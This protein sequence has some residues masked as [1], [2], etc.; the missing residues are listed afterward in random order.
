[1]D[2]NPGLRDFFESGFYEQYWPEA[3]DENS[4]KEHAMK[5]ISLLEARRGHI[6]DWRGGSGRY[7]IWFARSGFEVTLLDFMPLYLEKAREL[8]KKAGM[9]VRL[10]EADSRE[11][12]RDIQ[13]DFTV[14]LNNSVGFM[15]EVE[16][17]RAFRSLNAAL[18]PGAR[19]L[20]DCM[21]LF[22][23]AE[24]IARGG[25]ELQQSDGCTRRS[26]GHFDFETNVWYKTFELVQRNS[27]SLRKEFNQTIYT[28][29]QLSAM[30]KQAG[31][32]AERIF[33]DFDENPVSFDS[34]KIVLIAK[35]E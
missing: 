29:Q 27:S 28:P 9:P 1:M 33:G 23:L 14:C 30:L 22:F 5:V 16:E 20:V 19:L 10:I 34:R 25:Q 11:T 13:A 12:P 17:T 26:H 21:N 8:F 2:Q 18:K 7:A 35:K 31:F 6:L 4:V 24:P 32:I 15:S 3:N